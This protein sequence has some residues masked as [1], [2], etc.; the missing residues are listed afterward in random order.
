MTLA[1][2]NM[3]GQMS[4]APLPAGAPAMIAGGLTGDTAIAWLTA[5]G[6]NAELATGAEGSPRI[7]V[8]LNGASFDI[9]FFTG[10]EEADGSYESLQLIALF[11]LDEPIGLDR[12]NDWNTEKRFGTAALVDPEKVFVKMDIQLDGLSPLALKDNLV[13]WQAV[14]VEFMR[15][16]SA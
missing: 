11:E 10:N 1:Q 6:Y 16:F 9:A 13:L 2:E 7:R 15:F 3:S 5:W 4:P 12:I 8:A 14:M